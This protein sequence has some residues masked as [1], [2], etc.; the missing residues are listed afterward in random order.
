[1]RGFMKTR[2]AKG[3]LAAVVAWVIGVELVGWWCLD[4][5]ALGGE[6]FWPIVLCGV[7][8]FSIIA[9]ASAGYL[10]RSGWFGKRDRS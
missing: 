10:A 2:I 1:M 9:G 6:S 3:C 5:S 8:P 4:V 7:T